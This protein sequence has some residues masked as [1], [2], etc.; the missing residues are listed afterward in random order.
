[1]MEAV[2]AINQ[3]I[4]SLA[5][6]LNSPSLA[7]AGSAT[8][9]DPLV[10]VDIMMKQQGD[11]LYMFAVGMRNRPTHCTLTFD[12]LHKARQNATVEVVGEDRTLP[13]WGG[14]VEDDFGPYG[15]HIYKVTV[16]AAK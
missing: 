16:P 13:L 12:A 2:K 1:M 11:V 15:V 10:P 7:D 5:P 8:P 4:L 14:H 3:Q 9:D 6:V